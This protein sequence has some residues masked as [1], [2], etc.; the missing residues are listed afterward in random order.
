MKIEI[1]DVTLISAT[2]PHPTGEGTSATVQQFTRTITIAN[3][4]G[5]KLTIVCNTTFNTA[6]L[7]HIPIK[8][9]L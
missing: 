8:D 4:K 6:L 7:I 3:R 2:L 9:K 5:E 1:D